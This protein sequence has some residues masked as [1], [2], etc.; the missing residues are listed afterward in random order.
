MCSSDPLQLANFDITRV[1]G[2]TR[3]D[4]AFPGI[5]REF[6]P[7]LD[8]GSLLFMPSL[9][10]SASLSQVEDILARQDRAIREVPEVATVVGKAGRAESALDPAPIGMFETIILLKP[11]SQWR[12]VSHERWHS[13]KPW[14]S[15][16]KPLLGRL[17]PEES[18]LT[19]EE[20]LAELEAKTA[21]PGVL[22]TWLQPIQTRIVM[23]QT[24]FRAMMGVK[25][26]GSD[27]AEIERIGLQMEPL[28]HKVT[29]ATDVVA[30]RIVGKPYIQY[31]IDREAIARYGVSI[32]DVQ[33]VI[34]IAIGGE[35]LTVSV[36]GREKIGRAHV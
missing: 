18:P 8:E 32:R 14:L 29:G 9:L 28:L 4:R 1:P 24:G 21:M 31:E 17:W 6:M 34:E 15:F 27:V 5:G 26:F 35:N 2:W 20:L 30:D 16:A 23:L 13:R 25:I 19:K 10:P 22:P 7:P 36:E 11:E 3:L 12:K 33:D